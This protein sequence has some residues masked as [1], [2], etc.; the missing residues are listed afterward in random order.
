MR[1]ESKIEIDLCFNNYISKVE[2]KIND[3]PKYFWRYLS[4]KNKTNKIPLYM[5]L[6]DKLSDNCYDSSNLFRK[7]FGDIY[8]TFVGVDIPINTES[9]EY[10]S[11]TIST[12][13]IIGSL[14]N[15]KNSDN[16]GLDG[17]PMSLLK[18]TLNVIA[19]PLQLLFQKSIDEKKTHPIWKKYYISPIFKS[20]EQSSIQNYRPVSILSATP[21]ILDDIISKKI[22]KHFAPMIINNQHGFVKG[23]STLTN[24]SILLN[25]AFEAFRDKDQLDCI[26]TDFRKAFD[27][28]NK[29]VLLNKMYKYK[30]PIDIILWL[31][32]YLQNRK[33]RIK[34]NNVYSEWFDI[35]S[36]VPQGSQL[37]PIL[38]LIFINDLVDKLQFSMPLLF[39]D[40]LKLLFRIE[41]LMDC[42]NLQKDLDIIVDWCNRNCMQIN[43]Q[44][45]CVI[46]LHRRK[47]PILHEYF[48]NN[49]KINRVNTVKDLGI[50]IDCNLKFNDH[51]NHVML[52]A[53]RRWYNI[54]RNTKDFK[55]PNTIKV[56]YTSLIRS[57]L[58]YG[59][60]IWKPLY[61]NAMNRLEKIQHKALR[62][63]AYMDGNAMDRFNHNYN[64][65]STKYQ[66]PSISSF[67]DYS[68]LLFLY[69]VVTN[70]TCSDIKDCYLIFEKFDYSL[71]FIKPFKEKFFSCKFMLQDPF[72]R[73]PIMYNDYSKKFTALLDFQILY[74][75][76]KNFLKKKVF[77]YN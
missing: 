76:M 18:N 47:N 1:S 58:T 60:V 29:N 23:R 55:N 46:T 69:N 32:S 13:D 66:I 16:A 3:D 65:I 57:V 43:V 52:K 48:I 5:T 40:D 59:S 28:V 63:I 30:F 77:R 34:V 19:K 62:K 39:A 33:A 73:I 56:L 41:S 50:Y 38:F 9:Y 11:T 70:P 12:E 27:L 64:F 10:E 74:E 7:F 42:K 6:Y 17:I 8:D 45:C 49:V 72:I 67:L 25:N 54:V 51:L 53:N 15:V 36:G 24:L 14:K 21:K 26:Y 2:E 44:K 71:R 35:T 31:D 37:G 20:G 22:Y 75:N 68:D 61:Q 4:L